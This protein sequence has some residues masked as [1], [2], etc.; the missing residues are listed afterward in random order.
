MTIIGNRIFDHYLGIDYMGAETPTTSLKGL[1]VYL[2]DRSSPHE[3]HG[4]LLW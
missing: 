3:K 4:H 2:A 1:R